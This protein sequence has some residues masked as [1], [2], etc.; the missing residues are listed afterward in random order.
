MKISV[1]EKNFANFARIFP[2]NH[3]IALFVLRNPGSHS[4]S[5]GYGVAG[6]SHVAMPNA[7]A[8]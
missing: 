5:R 4:L 8:T 2:E 6:G 3:V 1:F 7:E